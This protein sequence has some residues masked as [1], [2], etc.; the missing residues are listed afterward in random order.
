MYLDDNAEEKEVNPRGCAGK[1]Y[2]LLSPK[3]SL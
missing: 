2:L 3:T 1:V